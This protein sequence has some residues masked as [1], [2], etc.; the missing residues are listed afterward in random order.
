MANP[1]LNANVFLNAGNGATT[2]TSRMTVSGTANKT[3]LLLAILAV[4]AGIAWTHPSGAFALGGLIVGLMLAL[5]ISFKPNTAPYLAPV[6][7]VAEGLALGTVSVLFSKAYHGIVPEAV[8]ATLGTAF[9]L[10]LAYKAGWIRVTDKF[11]AIVVAATMGVALVYLAQMA[12]GFFHVAIPGINGNGAVGILFSVVVVGIAAMNL[13]LDFDMIE[14]G[15]ANGA[16]K[17]MEWYAA[18][19][20][21]VTLVWL[22]LEILRLLS[23]AQSR[24]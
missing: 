4:S 9:A 15:A 23:K 19:G 6:Y 10:M 21:L 24:N 20:L 11:R 2:D 7:A 17:Y 14:T 16:P 13:V 3:S 18:F 1:T 5:I 12:L 8:L 22:Y